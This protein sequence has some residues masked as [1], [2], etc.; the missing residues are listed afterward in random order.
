VRVE[1]FELVYTAAGEKYFGQLRGS[2]TRTD[3]RGFYRI[4]YV[5]YGELYAVARPWVGRPIFPVTYY[6]GII[7][8]ENAVPIRV[9]SGTT[10]SGIDIRLG[11]FSSLFR[12][13]NLLSAGSILWT[14]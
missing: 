9:L 8:A 5:E 14:R 12:V 1:L 11:A 7:D 2:G 13:M 3:E 4:T 6:P 10:V